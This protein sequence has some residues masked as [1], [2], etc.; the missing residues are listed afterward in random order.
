MPKTGRNSGDKRHFHVGVAEHLIA[1][2]QQ[3]GFSERCWRTWIQQNANMRP[4][5][6]YGRS[7]PGNFYDLLVGYLLWIHDETGY[8]GSVLRPVIPFFQTG[9]THEPRIRTNSG[10]KRHFNVGV[11]EHL[12]AL[13]QQPGFSERCWR[14]WIQQNANMGIPGPGDQSQNVQPHQKWT[15]L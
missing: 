11:A 3:P 6:A 12:I 7:H 1:Q 4:R 14:T 15:P 9:S 13:F 5:R 10:Y 2:F 8:S